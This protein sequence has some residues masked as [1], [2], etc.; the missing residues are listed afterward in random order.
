MKRSLTIA[1]Y[2][3]NTFR[4]SAFLL[5]LITVFFYS[6]AMAQT[7][8]IINYAT[9]GLSTKV[10]N[11]FN[12]TPAPVIG[13]VAHY[14]LAGGVVFLGS[15]QGIV[16]P[17][18]A[19]FG[20]NPP[21]MEGIA[22]A[23]A[24]T[25]VPDWS[26]TVTIYSTLSSQLGTTATENPMAVVGTL[27]TSK[28]EADILVTDP[29][30]CNF[31]PQTSWGILDS[32]VVGTVY[33]VTQTPDT[34]TVTFLPHSSSNYLFIMAQPSDEFG[35]GNLMISKVVIAANPPTFT[36]S[37]AAPALTCYSTSTTF[38][39]NNVYGSYGVT[40]YTWN[41]G[42]NSGWK[43]NQNG[44]IIAAPASISTSADSLILISPGGTTLPSSISVTV[45]CNGSNYTSNS[46]VPTYFV[47]QPLP[48]VGPVGICTSAS[49][50]IPTLP[51]GFS[52]TNWSIV[53]GGGGSTLSLSPGPNSTLTITNNNYY[54]QTTTLT[55]SIS[56]ACFPPSTLQ[57]SAASSSS[58]NLV[59]GVINQGPCYSNE[60]LINQTLLNGPPNF[61]YD[62]CPSITTI[63]GQPNLHF[64]LASGTPSEYDLNGN[65]LNL[66]LNGGPVSFSVYQF[67]GGGCPTVNLSFMP[68]SDSQGPSAV[69]LAS[70]HSTY[71]LSP[72]PAA[73]IVT[74][75]V[76]SNDQIE[77]QSTDNQ[78]IARSV[79][80]QTKGMR[81]IETVKIFDVNGRLRKSYKYG[82]LT[83]MVQLDVSHL[84]TGV[85]F[86]EIF[87][88]KTK[89][90]KKFAVQH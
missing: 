54:T 65:L 30:V 64:S 35:N 5:L 12:T 36:I 52:V 28:Y 6:G 81:V 71:R 53:G 58:T 2:L 1:A 67:Q 49:Y 61:I 9:S 56:G 66:T 24:Y 80:G 69:M 74:I 21:A 33:Y 48:I 90:V 70:D 88:G 14:P 76:L 78:I 27:T 17:T 15:P 75:D 47:P 11:V 89:E 57:V 34:I 32:S 39:A 19:G 42:V 68:L 77:A 20:F 22:Y 3:M 45:S 73:G 85:Y 84:E 50:S 72:N 4:S 41:I 29:T 86:A 8:T 55:A 31:V 40:G 38:K 25:T 7:T 63:S 23:M 13:G 59:S 16:L 18:E 87:N 26:Y 44:T 51:S 37:P 46:A 43:Y 83:T 60:T 82:G 79:L 62:Y 10:C